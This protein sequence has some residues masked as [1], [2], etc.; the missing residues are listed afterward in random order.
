MAS[1]EKACAL[2]NWKILQAENPVN[3]FIIKECL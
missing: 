3:I 2:E 1:L